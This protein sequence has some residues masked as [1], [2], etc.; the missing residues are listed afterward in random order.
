MIRGKLA[1]N[2]R[3]TNSYIKNMNSGAMLDSMHSQSKQYNTAASDQQ[4]MI[5]VTRGSNLQLIPLT[6]VSSPTNC[7]SPLN[8]FSSMML[9]H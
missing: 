8:N 7:S 9:E 2:N 1:N 5:N 3:N 6:E 4:V